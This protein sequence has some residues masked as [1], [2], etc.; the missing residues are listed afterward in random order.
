MYGASHLESGIVGAPREP[1]IR[2]AGG[3]DVYC[4]IDSWALFNMIRLL[5]P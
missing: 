5:P 2:G 4:I 3:G 1:S